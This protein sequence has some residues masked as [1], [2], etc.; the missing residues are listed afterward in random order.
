MGTTAGGRS[1]GETWKGKQKSQGKENIRTGTSPETL[2]QAILDNLYYVQGRPPELATRNDWYMALAYTVR[3]RLL[4]N[5]V[6]TL[7]TLAARR[8]GGELSLGGI[9]AGAAVG[10]QPHQSGH[11]GAGPGSCVPAW[12]QLGG[13]SGTGGGARSGQRRLGEAGRLLPGLP[14]HPGGSRHRLRHPL[15][16]R[17][18]RPG[19]PGR[20]AGGDHGQMA[21]PGQS[22]GDLPAGNHL[23]GGLEGAHR[24]L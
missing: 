20:L 3:D 19:N 14:G 10:Q 4:H 2:A 11:L 18:L 23:S 22:L 16:I 9:F 21:G 8:Q 17:H 15:R 7:K 5:W 1:R 13:T 24:N 12:A 6:Q